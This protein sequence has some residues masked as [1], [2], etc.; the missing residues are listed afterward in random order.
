MK[1]VHFIAAIV[2]ALMLASCSNKAPEFANS[3]PDNAVAVMTMHPMQI[4]SKGQI[5]S[6]ESLVERGKD[7]IYGMLLED[8]MSSG[9]RMD[10][11]S[12]L[13]VR[14]EEEAPV[15][16]MISGMKDE[17]KFIAML[18]KTNADIQSEFTTMET[19]TYVQPDEQGIIGWNAEQMIIL[20]KR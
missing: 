12:Y 6:F 4:H 17:E 3:I 14:M 16:G 2:V 10:E 9:L 20:T 15:I 18:E 8:P 19:Y 13:F 1:H 5:S 7:E 11:Y